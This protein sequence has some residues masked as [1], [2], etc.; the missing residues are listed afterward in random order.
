MI[1]T[2]SKEK[3]ISRLICSS[4]GNAGHA[5]AVIG[6]NLG[7]PVDVYVPVT[8]LTLMI[9]KIKK[10][11]ARVF[12][13]GENWNAADC[14]AREALSRDPD[15]KYIPPYDHPLIWDGYI[16]IVEE[17][18]LSLGEENKPD[19]IVLSVGGGGLLRGIQ[20][21]LKKV[22]WNDVK[23]LAVE[24]E[25]AASYAA[26]SSAGKVVKLD[27]ISTVASSLGALSVTASVLDS[28]ICTESCIV[29]DAEAVHAC[30]SFANEYRI[31]VEPACGAALAAGVRERLSAGR[32]EEAARRRIVVIACGGSAV[33]LDM[34]AAWNIRFPAAGQS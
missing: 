14:F 24:T 32:S 26:A 34:L 5:V 33:D 10:Q 9:N 28:D 22:G 27:K 8:T 1:H 23:I 19:M 11:E 25:G 3:N 6:N 12:V 15:S 4:G 30:I 18:K 31:L 20:L 29:T 17:I 16:S 7:I 13:G 2:L 21:G